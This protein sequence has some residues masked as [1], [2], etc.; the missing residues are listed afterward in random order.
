MIYDKLASILED[1][2]GIPAEDIRP[3]TMI[4]E[5]LAIDSLDLYELVIAMEEEFAIEF[6]QERIN[7]IETIEDVVRIL[8][9]VGVE[10]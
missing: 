5:D 1:S 3:D 10:D 2:F 9:E 8:K 7:E 4:I 6:P